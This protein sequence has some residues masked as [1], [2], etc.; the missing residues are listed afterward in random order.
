M[1]ERHRTESPLDTGLGC[2]ADY[3]GARQTQSGAMYTVTMLMQTRFLSSERL[4]AAMHDAMTLPVPG[5]RPQHRVPPGPSERP[6]I[7]NALPA[8]SHP[9][10][11]TLRH[12][13]GGAVTPPSG[14]KASISAGTQWREN[15]Q[16][17]MTFQGMCTRLQGQNK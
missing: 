2:A 1:I 4:P 16:L 3:V 9:K 7:C 15:T 12:S 6:T 13:A 11:V 8:H 14:M 17:C 5:R 10:E